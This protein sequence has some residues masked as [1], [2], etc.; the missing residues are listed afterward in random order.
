VT[1]WLRAAAP[2]LAA[3]VIAAPG[4]VALPQALGTP[5]NLTVEATSPSGA[6]VTYSVTADDPSAQIA[7]NPASGSVFPLESTTVLCTA[8]D[9]SSASFTVTVVDTTPPAFSKVTSPIV[10]KVNGVRNAVVAYPEPV[11]RDAVDGVVAVTCSP[12][13]KSVFDLGQ[14]KVICTAADKHGNDDSVSFFVRVLDTVPP[15]TVTDVVVR[16]D[17]GFVALTWRLPRSRDVAGTEIVRFPGNVVV[18]RGPGKSAT[19]A[20]LRAGDRYRYVI[21]SYDWANNRSRRVAV[22]AL[23]SETKLIQPQDGASLTAPPLLAWQAVTPANYYNVQL[24]AMQPSGLVKV[25]S[26]WPTTNH[27]Q[28]DKTWVYQGKSHELTKGRYRW[29]VWPG[30]GQIVL[31]HYGELI[32]SNTFTIDG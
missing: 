32:G 13:T 4:A 7:C 9:A 19:D 12:P 26:I 2:L 27:L 6:I 3:A 17:E 23:A 22:V 31:A 1:K 11:A 29:Y 20:G 18:F 21:T 10:S 28:L 14:T 25:L 16:S 30:L 24:W 5:G 8:T 15:P